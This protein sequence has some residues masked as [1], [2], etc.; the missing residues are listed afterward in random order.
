MNKYKKLKQQIEFEIKC[1]IDEINESNPESKQIPDDISLVKFIGDYDHIDM[2]D[3][4]CLY[5]Y[6]SMRSAIKHIEEA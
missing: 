3:R 1:C 4:G 6:L 5:A 2:Y